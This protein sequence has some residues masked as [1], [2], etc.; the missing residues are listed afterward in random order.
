MPHDEALG[1]I[2]SRWRER[3]DVPA[4]GHTERLPA[5]F[6]NAW[7]MH[8]R[9]FA[10]LHEGVVVHAMASILSTALAIAEG[11]ENISG[12]DLILAEAVGCDIAATLGLAARVRTVPDGNPDANAP[13]RRRPSRSA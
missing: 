10:C 4:W 5:A 2:A 3:C 6:L 1:T 8:N 9:E 11:R 7:Q 12:C 13:A